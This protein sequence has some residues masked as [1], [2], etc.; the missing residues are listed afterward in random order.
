MSNANQRF[1][2]TV[3]VFTIVGAIAAVL[4]IP[5]FR[6]L[7]RP[8]GYHSGVSGQE[9]PLAPP[10]SPPPPEIEVI[11]TVVEAT[12]PGWTNTGLALQRGDVLDIEVSGTVLFDPTI[13]EVG[14]DG[15]PWNASSVGHPNEF[16][17]P[18]EHLAA[19]IGKIGDRIFLIGRH[20]HEIAQSDGTLSLGI[21]ERWIPGAWDDNRGTFQ[22]S[23]RRERQ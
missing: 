13:Q 5:E 8:S 9:L 16:M 18:K 4:N 2:T 21:N 17:L 7:L 22:V 1:V 11:S 23:V 3:G 10:P 15:T 6:S 12:T 20:S 14:P 19:V